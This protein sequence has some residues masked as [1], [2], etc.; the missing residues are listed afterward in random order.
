[1]RISD[2]SSDV[3]SSDLIGIKA[4][5]LQALDLSVA[6]DAVIELP[7]HSC[8]NGICRAVERRADRGRHDEQVNAVA[9][10]IA[11]CRRPDKRK[12]E[13]GTGLDDVATNCIGKAVASVRQIER[14]CLRASEKAAATKCRV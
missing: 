6:L 5:L 1:M 7:D 10:Q 4:F 12:I 13:I 2:W 3:C 9:R 8:R 14:Q 11:Q